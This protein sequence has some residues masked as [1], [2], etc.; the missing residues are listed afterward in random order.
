MREV[1]QGAK[2]ALL[3]T[4]R[5]TMTTELL[6]FA[7]EQNGLLSVHELRE[8][9]FALAYRPEPITYEESAFVDGP[10]MTC[11]AAAR[12]RSAEGDTAVEREFQTYWQYL[13]SLPSQSSSRSATSQHLPRGQF[14]PQVSIS[15]SQTSRS[16]FTSLR[17]RSPPTDP[18]YYSGRSSPLSSF[19]F[20]DTPRSA[21]ADASFQSQIDSTTTGYRIGQVPGRPGGAGNG[22]FAPYA[23]YNVPPSTGPSHAREYNPTDSADTDAH[24]EQ[25]LVRFRI[26]EDEG[27]TFF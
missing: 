5:H 20:P 18:G 25:L 13:E 16:A 26:T 11:I 27:L 23:I 6:A 7:R 22:Q 19:S 1:V 4:F 14:M 17:P 9:F 12:E 2:L 3:E 24:F 8:A 15:S 10:T 21:Q